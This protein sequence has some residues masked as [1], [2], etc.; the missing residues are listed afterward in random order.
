[1]KKITFFLIFIL[2]ISFLNALIGW[3]GNIWPNSETFQIDGQDITI[4]YQIWKD[5]IT[6]G[7]GQG[8]DISAKL[9]YKLSTQTE[10]VEVDMPYLGE[11]GNNDEYST[12]IP[13]SFFSE[14]DIVNFYCEG[15]DASDETYSYGTD[16][17]GAGPFDAE[18]PGI[19]YIGSPTE[20]DVTVTF[21]VNMSLVDEIFDVSVAGTFNEW[22]SGQ[23]LLT[24][25]DTDEIYTGDVL[26]P[27][28]SS[29]N[30]EYKFINGGQ[31]EDQIGNRSFIVDDS[32]PTQILDVVYFNDQN[33]NDY[34]TQDVTI[35]FNVDVADSAN[36]GAIF[37][38]LS[39]NGNVAPLDWDFADMNNPLTDLGNN[40]WT[41]ELLFPTGSWKYLEFKF[42]R[43]GN[44]YE[45]GFEDN[46]LATI[47]DSS[48][49]QTIDCIYGQMGSAGIDENVEISNP[50]IILNN[51]PNPFR[52]STT[53]S[54]S[55]TEN[56]ENAE[57]EIYN[58]KGQ[59]VKSLECVNYFDAKATES[60]SHIIWNG[61]DEN[62]KPV[63]SGIYFYK[64]KS[65]KS[66]STKKM[67]LMR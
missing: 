60:L 30:Q 26:I 21:Q 35:T 18:N 44:D 14:N 20:Q 58:I 24:D 66:V 41:I 47:D 10:Y 49:T 64:L 45:A 37:N 54:F 55:P 8:V 56:G 51:Y 3:S 61:K 36:A 2:V 40:L 62:N 11:V 50:K 9:Y 33:P 42:A 43:N 7:E 4:Y 12:S 46:H 28:G 59:K 25:P 15:Y 53:I 13:N 27:A 16:Q 1:M 17:N 34:T 5:G 19:Y 31:W 65:G 57:I 29:Q 23:D 6:P 38:T 22:T 48:P 63:S 52:N 39:I 67:I 32:S